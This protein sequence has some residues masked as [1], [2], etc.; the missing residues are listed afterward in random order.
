MAKKEKV[1]I[2]G[3]SGWKIYNFRLNLVKTLISQNFD[4]IILAP[5][6]KYI[7]Y[8][9]S[10]GCKHYEVKMQNQGKNPFIELKLLFEIYFIIKKISPNYLLQFT[11]KPNIYGS[12][13]SRFLKIKTLNNITGLGSFIEKDNLFKRFIILLY[14]FSFK[15][16]HTVFF[17]NNEDQNIFLK[18][19]IVTPDQ[20]EVIPGSGIDISS[21]K[22]LKKKNSDKL[23]F[24]LASR[25]IKSKGILDYISSAKIIKRKFP[26][27]SFLLAGDFDVNKKDSINKS[28]IHKYSKDNTINYLGFSENIIDYISES[29]CIVFPSYYHEGVPRILLESASMEKP[30]ITTNHK[31]C[32]DVVD[33]GIN[34]FLCEPKNPTDLANKIANFIKLDEN[35]RKKMGRNSRIKVLKEFDEQIVIKKYLERMQK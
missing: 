1:L 3:N 14:K 21:F 6:D 26:N 27:T 16:V 20:C 35:A 12:I 9:I 2:F 29:D 17:Q 19:K 11:I 23:V 30:L 18:K 24:L 7:K 32:K 33:H 31:G 28:F 15:K 34:G 10:I 22:P 4:V 13:V 8:L 5:K 25:I